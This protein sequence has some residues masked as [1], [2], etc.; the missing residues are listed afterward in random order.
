[1]LA[2][3]TSCFV[4][5]FIGKNE[6]VLSNIVFLRHSIGKEYIVL[7]LLNQTV[8]LLYRCHVSKPSATVHYNETGRKEIR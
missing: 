7:S 2:N 3:S 6:F 5:S 8:F 1:M 4:Q